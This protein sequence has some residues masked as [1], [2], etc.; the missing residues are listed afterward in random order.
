MASISVHFIFMVALSSHSVFFD[1]VVPYSLTL[2]EID[3]FPCDIVLGMRW[4]CCWWWFFEDIPLFLVAGQ[5]D[6][7]PVKG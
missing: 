3:I 5:N 2:S 7:E 6:W 1:K 4:C